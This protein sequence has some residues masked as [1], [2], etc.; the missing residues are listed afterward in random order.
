[1]I[2]EISSRS[3][4]FIVNRMKD[5]SDV[6]R[7]DAFNVL[8]NYFKSVIYENDIT[9]FEQQAD[10][11]NMEL[12]EGFSIIFFISITIEFDGHIIFIKK[13]NIYETL[14]FVILCLPTVLNLTL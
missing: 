4:L 6:V 7:L 9:K 13:K 11:S 14:K 2:F 1:M 10:S 5:S 3:I 12:N 8:N